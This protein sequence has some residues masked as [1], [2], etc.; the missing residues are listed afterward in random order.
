MA[1]SRQGEPPSLHKPELEKVRK[2][3]GCLDEDKLCDIFTSTQKGKLEQKMRTRTCSAFF[4]R[5]ETLY[6][7]KQQ[8]FSGA[9]NNQSIFTTK[10]ENS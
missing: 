1:Q 6:K 5:S 8:R 10:F 9:P 4:Q 3:G 2:V 7:Q